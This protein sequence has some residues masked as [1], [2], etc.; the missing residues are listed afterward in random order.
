MPV[1]QGS[2][3]E[4]QQRKRLLTTSD[5]LLIWEHN[6]ATSS[7]KNL[8]TAFLFSTIPVTASAKSYQTPAF[9]STETP[10]PTDN[11]FP[12]SIKLLMHYFLCLLENI[13]IFSIKDMTGMIKKL[14]QILASFCPNLH[15]AEANKN[16][17][18][19]W[20]NCAIEKFQQVAE[21]DANKVVQQFHPV[22]QKYQDIG[23]C[24]VEAVQTY[25]NNI[26][27][28]KFLGF[29]VKCKPSTYNSV[30]IFK[31]L[32]NDLSFVICK[33]SEPFLE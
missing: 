5:E 9:E 28:D 2:E 30:Q 14:Q 19:D 32:L 31:F 6:T 1:L 21:E 10:L 17:L 13:D 11:N 15:A 26:C 4:R 8:Y 12:E 33:I 29:P 3:N 18:R 20:L 16:N 7:F 27:S 24:F 23:N 25:C 22:L